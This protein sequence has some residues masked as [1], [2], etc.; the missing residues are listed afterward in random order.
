MREM[1]I[2]QHVET[3]PVAHVARNLRSYLGTTDFDGFESKAIINNP[4]EHAVS[5]S[6]ELCS[7]RSLSR[8]SPEIIV[9]IVVQTQPPIHRI[10]H[11]W[12]EASLA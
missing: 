3:L 7:L 12:T 8:L 1:R 11:R 9:I 4:T 2:Q 6:E 5:A 10:I